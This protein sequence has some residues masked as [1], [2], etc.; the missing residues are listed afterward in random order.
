MVQLFPSQALA[1]QIKLRSSKFYLN[2]SPA[3]A[4]CPYDYHGFD[5]NFFRETI[6]AVSEYPSDE[7]GPLFCETPPSFNEVQAALDSL[8]NHKASGLDGLFNEALKTGGPVL[9]RSLTLLF[10]SMWQ[11]ERS[12]ILLARAT[13]HLILKGHEA[14][15]ELPSSYRP[16]SLTSSVSKVFERVLLGRLDCYSDAAMLFP[17]EQA[18]FRKGR[19][20]IEQAYILREILDYRKRLDKITT[21]LCFVDLQSAFPSTW[22]EDM[23]RRLHEANVSGKMY[24]LIRSLY[25]DC[26]SAVITDNGLTDWFPVENGTRQGAVLSP[27]L[28]SLLISPLVDE[29]Q[30][31]GMG[32]AF[33]HLR[34]GCLMFADDIVLIADSEKDLQSMMNVASNFF[35]K[36]RFQVSAGKTRVVSLGHRETRILRPRFWHIGGKIVRDYASYTYLA[37][38]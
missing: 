27:F 23:W 25:I 9:T 16:I 36:W 28:F 24:R 1:P 20:P 8:L 31:L 19:S 35:R 21:F 4:K 29:L 3:Y 37:R 15:P 10:Q 26:S 12:P 17:E 32:T 5:P 2:S 6:N 18:G 13:I 14:D 33:E 11:V 30:A 34:I 22:R 38:Y 7:I